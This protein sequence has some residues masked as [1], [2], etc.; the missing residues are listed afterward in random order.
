MDLDL[1]LDLDLGLD[2][3]EKLGLGLWDEGRVERGVEGKMEMDRG[4]HRGM[5]CSRCCVER[6]VEGEVWC[7]GCL[8][9]EGGG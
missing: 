6:G 7:L 4:M 1:D 9:V 2:G 3:D 5:V 8:R